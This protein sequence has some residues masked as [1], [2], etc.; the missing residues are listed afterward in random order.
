M[1]PLISL[2]LL[3][4]IAAP[5]HAAVSTAAGK[6][7][8]TANCAGCHGAKAQGGAGPSLHGAAGW[9]YALFRRA[10]LQDKDDHGAP[11]KPPM[12]NWGKIGFKGDH[13]K[14]PTDTEI[15]NLQAYLKTLK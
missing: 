5:A 15:K 2:L 12:P 14:P 1:R 9:S 10:M 6:A 11:L 13:G 7:I 3:A 4:A 8:Y